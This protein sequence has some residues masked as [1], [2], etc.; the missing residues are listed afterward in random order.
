MFS[1]HSTYNL[2]MRILLMTLS[3]S[4]LSLL[5]YA[6]IVNIIIIKLNIINWWRILIYT[7]LIIN[8]ITKNL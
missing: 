2:L 6:I 1:L 7:Y 8:R 4:L 3:L 5:I